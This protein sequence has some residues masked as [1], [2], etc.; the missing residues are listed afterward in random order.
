MRNFID[1]HFSP[2]NFRR[3]L[4]L[5]Q[6]I[7]VPFGIFGIW[8]FLGSEGS[9]EFLARKVWWEEGTKFDWRFWYLCALGYCFNQCCMEIRRREWCVILTMFL[10]FQFLSSVFVF[11]SQ[12][13][14]IYSEKI[15]PYFWI[16][17][18]GGKKVYW[19]RFQEFGRLLASIYRN[20]FFTYYKISKTQRSTVINVRYCTY[21]I[22]SCIYGASLFLTP[23]RRGLILGGT[24]LKGIT[25]FQSKF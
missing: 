25:Y 7:C 3:I 17:K 9:G 21:R 5:L 2:R 6:L 16:F 12:R 1:A 15:V 18:Q 11:Y 10:H 14:D 4:G 13:S 20:S 19:N 24:R 22:Y 8:Y 23:F